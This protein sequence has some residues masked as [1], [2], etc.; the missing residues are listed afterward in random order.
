M[1]LI[2]EAKLDDARELAT[3]HITSWRH[4][5]KDDFPAEFLQG[6]DIDRRESWF[7]S[8]IDR[9][10]GL[11]VAEVD[12]SP[13]GF[14]FFG[15]SSDEGWGEVFAI[16]VHP[17]RWGEGHGGRLLAAT[18]SQLVERGFDRALLWVL[19]TNRPAREFYESRGW[20]LGKPIKLEEIGGRQV[21]EVRYERSLI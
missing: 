7:A 9:G 11:L 16:Y 19:E 21:T 2:R 10:V 20:V 8:Q 5:Y 13:V 1:S 4:T 17:D 3:I 18:E 6:L 15:K 12:D 14:C